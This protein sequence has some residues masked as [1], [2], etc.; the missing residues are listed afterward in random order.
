MGDDYVE[1]VEF[2]MDLNSYW[3]LAGKGSCSCRNQ[4]VPF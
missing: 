4:L 2:E 1:E 3:T